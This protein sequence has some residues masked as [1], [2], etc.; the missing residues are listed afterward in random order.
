MKG[1]TAT[2]IN[3]VTDF[4]WLDSGFSANGLCT[5]NGTIY[6][7]G[8]YFTSPLV[9]VSTMAQ[10]A[11]LSTGLNETNAG[12]AASQ[13]SIPT[14][15][16][17]AETPASSRL[18]I[19]G[20]VVGS[21]IEAVFKRTDLF[22]IGTDYAMYHK[23]L[24]GELA[25]D[26][27]S[28]WED[29]G[30][31][32]VSAPAAAVWGTGRVD[33]FGLGTDHAMYQ[34]TLNNDTWSSGWQRL[35]GTFTS[36]G[37][38]VF[39][40][41][42]QMYLLVRDEN[43]MLRSSYTDGTTWTDF[44]NHGGNLASAPVAVSREGGFVD[45]FAIFNDGGLY[46]SW[47]DTQIWNDWEPLGGSYV[48][49]PAAVCRTAGQID[50]FVTGSDQ[51]LYHHS[52]SNNSW[53]LPEKLAYVLV[54]SPTVSSTGPEELDLFIPATGSE[55]DH[56]QWNGQTWQYDSARQGMRLPWRYAFSIDDIRCINPRSPVNDTDAAS[57]SVAAGNVPTITATQW[58]G[59]LGK[60]Q[61]GA[62][63]LLN[64]PAVTVDLAEPM[65]FSYQ[66]VN[67]GSADQSDIL[68][69]LASGSNSLSLAATSSMEADIEQG[70]VK[71][72]SVILEGATKISIP[73][74]GSILS[75][76][77]GWLINQL[78]GFISF[79]RCD[80][81][82]AAEMRAMFGRDLLM[83]TNNGTTKFSTTTTHQGTDSPDGCG[84]NSIYEVTWSIQ[85]L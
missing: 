53:A 74:V 48:G 85:P 80:G 54:E 76:A 28:D 37:S 6:R 71:I 57:L 75:A 20:G 62:T 1:I 46:H 52:F 64:I 66:V 43:F 69:A 78:A 67:N 77:E 56:L 38:L 61:Q 8:G 3:G 50:V 41:P 70:I 30:G 79:G 49:E 36:A 14:T 23:Q 72:A 12:A 34:R 81:M 73:V 45:V 31:V 82:V 65:S 47:W 7:F 25:G 24:W 18:S 40:A 55:L 17:L 35:G 29:L 5:P 58:L 44:E 60:T 13:P 10:H 27:L 26:D 32:F 11:V 2:A 16:S 42:D 22:G 4:F 9:A 33:V 59:N 15:T 39:T 68:A 21:G 84:A 51:H 19:K 63:N 83:L